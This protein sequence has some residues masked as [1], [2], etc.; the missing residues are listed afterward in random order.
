MDTQIILGDVAAAAAHF[1]D[2]ATP[3]CDDADSRPDSVPIRAGPHGTD[4]HPVVRP[5]P[6][7]VQQPR[8]IV[9][10]VD[11]DIDGAI[12]VVIEKGHAAT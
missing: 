12:V 1:G 4:R 9:L 8:R 11:G 3:G 6:N 5:G 2:M 10:V 7:I